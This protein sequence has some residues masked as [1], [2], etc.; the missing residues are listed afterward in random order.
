MLKNNKGFSLV[1][2]MV[3]VAIIGVLAAVAIPNVSKYM[4][5]A[6]QSE[7]KVTLSSL[8]TANKAFF[9]EYGI[10]DPQ[11][12]VVGF[13]PSGTMRYNA[14]FAA[15]SLGC[16]LGDYGYTTAIVNPGKSTAEYCGAAAAGTCTVLG[17]SGALTGGTAFNCNARTFRARAQG[18]IGT[19]NAT[20][21][22]TID[23]N[24]N[25]LNPTD[26]T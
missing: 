10:Y 15:A 24:K 13:Q 12:E 3:V 19:R 11:L 26:G 20:D 2:L 8:Y 17:S 23:H 21:V 7:A 1:E 9:A 14:G 5:K 16:I 18:K 6:R 25:L 4:A 22:W